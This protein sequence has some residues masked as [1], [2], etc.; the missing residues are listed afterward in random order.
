[1]SVRVGKPFDARDLVVLS[2]KPIQQVHILRYL[3]FFI[4]PN[5]S[6]FISF[7]Y[8]LFFQKLPE[9]LECFVA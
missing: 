7:L 5:H 8:H 2:L 3:G 4:D 1:M 6:F 9:E